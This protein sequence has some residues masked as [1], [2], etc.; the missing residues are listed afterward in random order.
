[1]R[2]SDNILSYCTKNGAITN[3][4]SKNICNQF[5]CYF[6]YQH[7]NYCRYY[8]HYDYYRKS[9]HYRP[10]YSVIIIDYVQNIFSLIGREEF[11]IGRIA[12]RK[13]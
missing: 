7:K 6:Y 2:N 9:L 11:N 13:K 3:A 1:M 4:Y 8:Y 12:L 5:Y 10:I